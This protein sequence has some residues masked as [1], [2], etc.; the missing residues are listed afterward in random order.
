MCCGAKVFEEGILHGQDCRCERRAG[1]E[2]EVE[3]STV[4]DSTVQDSTYDRMHRCKGTKRDRVV[5][6]VQ[7]M[8]RPSTS[9][10]KSVQLRRPIL[11]SRD[12]DLF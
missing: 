4:E 8:R 11:K 1:T 9:K 10:A 7:K 2:R 5:V 3:D 6:P 12:R